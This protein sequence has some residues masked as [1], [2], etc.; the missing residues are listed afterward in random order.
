MSV[1]SSVKNVCV[2]SQGQ[3]LVEHRLRQYVAMRFT[4]LIEAIE[5]QIEVEAFSGTDRYLAKTLA[6]V[7]AEVIRLPDEA[8][9]RIEKILRPA[10]D[11]K[12]VYTQIENEHIRFVISKFNEIDYPIKH[13]K[14]YFKVQ[15]YNSFFEAEI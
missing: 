4:E 1:K 3:S 12:E 10:L 5:R 6:A 13:P 11:V 8:E 15:L 14:A 9:I 7:M 2:K